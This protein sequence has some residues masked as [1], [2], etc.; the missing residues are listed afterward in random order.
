MY[1]TKY[2]SWGIRD[3]ELVSYYNGRSPDRR[4]PKGDIYAYYVDA[5]Y[6]T[7][8][9]GADTSGIE[10]F[11]IQYRQATAPALDSTVWFVYDVATKAHDPVLV[12]HFVRRFRSFVGRLTSRARYGK[13]G[14]MINTEGMN[15]A[16]LETVIA[17]EYNEVRDPL[18]RLGFSIDSGDN[19]NLDLGLRIA[20][21]VGVHI[22]GNTTRDIVSSARGYISSKSGILDSAAHARSTA[23]VT[24]VVNSDISDPA[25][26]TAVALF[27]AI[28]RTRRDQFFKPRTVMTI[29]G[30]EAWSRM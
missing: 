17:E 9:F 21:H 2:S 30:W 27:D 22:A 15:P 25:E 14:I 1:P 12:R 6:S 16:D 18:T 3:G 5:F 4:F 29:Q 28:P 10:S 20:D 11:L 8:A 19:G 24:F 13:L 23:S 7:S 26:A